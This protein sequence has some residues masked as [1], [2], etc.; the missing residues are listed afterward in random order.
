M[1]KTRSLHSF[2]RLSGHSRWWAGVCVTGLLTTELGAGGLGRL[3]AALGEGSAPGHVAASTQSGTKTAGSGGRQAV[4]RGGPT[5]TTNTKRN[6]RPRHHRVRLHRHA[7]LVV[8]VCVTALPTAARSTVPSIEPVAQ[9]PVVGGGGGG[10][11]RAV[12]HQ[13]VRQPRQKQHKQQSRPRQPSAT[14]VVVEPA[15]QV[16]QVVVQRPQDGTGQARVLVAA[17]PDPATST[18]PVALYGRV[19]PTSSTTLPTGRVC[20]YDGTSTT[21]LGCSTLAPQANGVMQ[22]HIKVPLTRGTHAIV[23]RYAGDAHYAAVQSSAL[24]LVVS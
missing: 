6:T 3:T 1:S 22:A 7:H 11:G 10:T 13:S 15:A 2:I 5:C 16:G 24:A 4:L 17:R 23:A 19:K 20:F 18:S 12:A 9:V 8:N 21:A 14:P